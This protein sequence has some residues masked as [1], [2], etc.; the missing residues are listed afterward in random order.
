[1]WLVSPT[2]AYN[3]SEL[4]ETH[5]VVTYSEF[6]EANEAILRDLPPPAVALDY[7]GERVGTAGD[8]GGG[9]PITNL[10]EVFCLMRDDEKSHV[11]S[12][13][14][15]QD[16]DV[17]SRARIVE[18]GAILT[19][20]AIFAGSVATVDTVEME[21]PVVQK[22]EQRAVQQLAEE[23]GEVKKEIGMEIGEVKKDI[24]AEIGEVKME[25]GA[26]IGEVKKEI[27]EVNKEIRVAVEEEEVVL[28]R[29]VE[30]EE[31]DFGT[32]WTRLRGQGQVRASGRLVRNPTEGRTAHPAPRACARTGRVL[33]I[34]LFVASDVRERRRR[35]DSRLTLTESVSRQHNRPHVSVLVNIQYS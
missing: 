27:G 6:A 10:Y 29:L 3:F 18:L 5:A 20:T 2:L 19:A 22:F 32:W 23:A 25:I 13:K 15:C 16:Q 4:I 21:I 34:L 11:E 14:G 28:E 31:A 12:M 7:Y 30:K 17:R 33:L 24:D 35:P 26:E 1:M 9:A 8:A